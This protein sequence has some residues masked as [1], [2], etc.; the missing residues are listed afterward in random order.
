[1]QCAGNQARDISAYDMTQNEFLRQFAEIVSVEPEFLTP[2][3]EMGS[4]PGWDSVTLLSAMVL[5]DSELGLTIRPEL[6]SQARTFGD[7][8]AAVAPKF[9]V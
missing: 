9:K 1:M 7:I 8:L 2:E 6:L 4:I 5:I 3:R